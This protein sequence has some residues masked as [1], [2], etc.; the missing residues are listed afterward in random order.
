M[1]RIRRLLRISL[2]YNYWMARHFHRIQIHKEC[3]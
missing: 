1:L 3:I 2:M